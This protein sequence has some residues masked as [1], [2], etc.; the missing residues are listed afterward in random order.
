[1]IF[2]T[3][4]PQGPPGRYYIVANGSVPDRKSK[5]AKFETLQEAKDFA[6]RRGIELAATRFIGLEE[7]WSHEL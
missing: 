7:F 1:V 4:A 5:A 3:P 6:K 2:A